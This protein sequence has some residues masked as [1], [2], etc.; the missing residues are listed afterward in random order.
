MN[1]KKIRVTP[2]GVKAPPLYL[3]WEQIKFLAK[4]W[5]ADKYCD[6]VRV[7]A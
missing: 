1:E 3:T 7:H 2:N 5:E 4:N 6:G